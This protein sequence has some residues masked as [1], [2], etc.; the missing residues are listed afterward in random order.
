MFNH[1]SSSFRGS[2]CFYHPCYVR[3]YINTC[4]SFSSWVSEFPSFIHLRHGK[5]V[6]C[7]SKQGLFNKITFQLVPVNWYLGEPEI[8]VLA[9]LLMGKTTLHKRYFNKISLHNINCGT[10]CMIST[11]RFR[12]PS[13]SE[14]H[15]MKWDKSNGCLFREL[16]SSK[17]FDGRLFLSIDTLRAKVL[18]SS[19]GPLPAGFFF[20]SFKIVILETAL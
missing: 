19:E 11:Q 6:I 16:Q 15:E 1:V 4:T 20:E 5:V 10:S 8:L 2:Q 18:Q 17:S 12:K 14:V 7:D 9:S 3:S 13:I